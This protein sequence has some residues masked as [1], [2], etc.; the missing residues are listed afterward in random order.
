[1][2]TI[3]RRDV[4][5]LAAASLLLGGGSARAQGARTTV[6][7]W[8]L[9]SAPWDIMIDRFR[10]IS[11]GTEIRWTKYG[12]D[13]IKQALRVAA[14][15][16][17][18]PDA[19]YNWGGSLASAYETGGQALDLTDR[20]TRD[21]LDK[22]LIP[23]AIRLAELNGRLYGIP[24]RITP[25]SFIYRKSLFDKVGAKPPK[26]FA[27][28]EDIAA[29]LKAVGI[30]PFGCGGK[31]SWLTMRF[32][33]FLLEHFA[34][35][36]LND[37]LMGIKASWNCPQVVATFAKLQEWVQKGYFPAGFLSVDPM[38]DMTPMFD[39]TAAMVVEVPSVESTRILPAKQDPADYG[40][41]VDPTDHTPVRVSG[42]I[43][44]IQISARASK[45]VQ[46]AIIR[47]AEM[48]VDQKVAQDTLEAFGGPSS[49]LNAMPTQT[50]PIQRQWAEW[51]QGE[52]SLYMIA[53]QAL[54]QPV[55]TAYWAAQD[56]VV[57]GTITPAAAA[58]QV[59]AA[60]E[61]WKAS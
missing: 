43:N 48:V 53:D 52:V 51:L 35:P 31:Y 61:A 14:S 42:F 8:A 40:T 32:T 50:L 15:A 2:I 1:M 60:I 5:K 29:R 39:G 25:V 47:F 55:A 57:L 13:A 19:W 24:Y 23:A 22:R 9:A 58:A 6:N 16:G 36:E 7:F 4:G 41:F 26:S 54:P 45:E 10:Q 12:T 17:A 11:P 44:Q 28:L 20:I 30:T 49:A 27:E 21:G 34:G 37:Q 33:D 46:E 3:T 59:Q 56:S 18:M 38:Q